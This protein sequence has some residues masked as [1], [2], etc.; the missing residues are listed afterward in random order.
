MSDEYLQKALKKLAMELSQEEYME[1]VIKPLTEANNK[2]ALI[3]IE[4]I[5]KEH[6]EEIESV[7]K[8]FQKVYDT[9]SEGIEKRK[10]ELQKE[11]EMLKKES[12]E[13]ENLP[14]PI[15]KTKNEYNY[16]HFGAI[17]DEET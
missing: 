17:M 4:K 6:P 7:K 11:I 16:C 9:W 8:S 1:F 12:K 14:K 10:N 13:L 3:S 2:K 5:K 15:L